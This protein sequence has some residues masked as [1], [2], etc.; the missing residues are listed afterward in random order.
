VSDSEQYDTFRYEV[1]NCR[2]QHGKL[3]RLLAADD[4]V[5][6][7][8]APSLLRVIDRN[9]SVWYS[10]VMGKQRMTFGQ[11]LRQARRSVTPDLTQEAAAKLAGVHSLTWSRWECDKRVP[12]VTQLEAIAAALGTTAARLIEE[13]KHG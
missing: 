2:C 3:V 7:F 10:H 1:K 5:G 12:D 9:L 4:K 6:L 8:F 11:K 13:P